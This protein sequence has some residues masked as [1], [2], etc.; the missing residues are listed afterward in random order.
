[1][2]ARLNIRLLLL[3]AA[4][5]LPTA[6]GFQLRGSTEVPPELEPVYVH[7]AH[8]TRI[9]G[10]LT[11]AL[12]DSGVTP[13]G[14]AKQAR[15]VIRILEETQDERVT[16]VNSRGKIIGTELQYRVAFDVMGGDGR[17]LVAQQRIDLARDY[18]HPDVE[19]IAGTEEAELIRND[20]VLD[21]ADRILRRLAAQ[22][23]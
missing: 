9:V 15:T 1:M 4:M 13:A 16:A 6:C 14:S 2:P 12:A 18:V 23:L 3:T 8:G 7:A 10:A 11:Q 17:P 19:V 5:L 21:M 20:M 22:L